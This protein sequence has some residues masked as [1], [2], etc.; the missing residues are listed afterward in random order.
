[1]WA[2]CVNTAML[3]ENGMP[4]KTPIVKLYGK[5]YIWYDNLREFGTI[6]VLTTKTPVIG[7]LEDR[8]TTAMFVGYSNNH[9][10]DT[11]RFI[12]LRTKKLIM[13]RDYRWLEKSWAQYHNI[14]K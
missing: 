8:G 11:Y 3:I 9:P 4:D 10:S 12:N 13:S 14:T 7:K 6:A 2:E 5:Q 1:M